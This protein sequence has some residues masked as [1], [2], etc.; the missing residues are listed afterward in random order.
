[1]TAS[2]TVSVPL[3]AAV[4]DKR[5]VPL[6]REVL[7]KLKKEGIVTTSVVGTPPR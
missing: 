7:E 5:K 1:M 3:M 6:R 4:A 2:T